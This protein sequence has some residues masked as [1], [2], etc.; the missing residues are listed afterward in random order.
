MKNQNPTMRDVAKLAGVTQPTVSYVINGTARVSDEV[1]EK[2]HQAIRELNYK[3]NYFARGLKTNKS[4]MIGIII[5]DIMNE[6]YA[7]MIHTMEHYL[8]ELGYAVI[9][10]STNYDV[11]AES[12]SI[13]HLIDY[14]VEGIIV[15]Y[16]IRSPEGLKILADSEKAAVILEGGDKC[17]NIPCIHTDNYDGGYT[18]AQYLID[19]GRKKIAYVGQ[20]ADIQALDDR[21]RGYKDA[22]RDNQLLYEGMLYEA[23]G[24]ADKWEEG[25]RLGK[26]L[27][28]KEIDAMIVSSDVLA[29]GIIKA[30]MTEGKKIP[31][32]VAV[33]GYDDIP[34]AQVFVPALTTMAQPVAQMCKLAVQTV[35][36]NIKVEKI[37]REIL[38]ASLIERET[39]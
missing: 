11:D 38:K 18:A 17:S 15:A 27:A 22:M 3:P 5:P 28:H 37:Q 21:C 16:Q 29:V 23:C 6:Y 8:A 13:R 4:R 14:N 32:D 19:H 33:I 7:G 35:T 9:I 20:N 10:S 31:E 12:K 39:T 1:K 26:I 34:L 25:R 36:Q 30:I 2:V 24:P